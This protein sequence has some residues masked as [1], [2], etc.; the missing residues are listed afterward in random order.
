MRIGIL[1]HSVPAA[2]GIVDAINASALGEAYI[3]V[4]RTPDETWTK[5][6]VKSIGRF[7]LQGGRILSLRLLLRGKIVHLRSTL[8]DPRA[9]ERLKSMNLD[10][11]L[12]KSGVIYRKPTIDAFRLGI[13]NAH[14]GILPRYRGRSVVEWALVEDGPVGV[15][16]FFVDEGIDTG[17]R[18]VLS[19]EVDISHCKSL[20]E[21]KEYLF[22]LDV[23]FYRGALEIIGR[24]DGQFVPSTGP[25]RRYFV[26]SRLLKGAVDEILKSQKCVE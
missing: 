20:A 19:E 7:V 17:L 21:A 23:S 3:I 5:A 24:G 1:T 26:M 4:F 13:L 10:V 16:V 11:G 6:R 9:T 8:D 25:S 22:G 18:I 12:H 15:T 14:I 2:L